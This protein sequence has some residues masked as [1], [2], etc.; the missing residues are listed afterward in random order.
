MAGQVHPYK[1][2]VCKQ[3]HLLGFPCKGRLWKSNTCCGLHKEPS[4]APVQRDYTSPRRVCVCV[5]VCVCMCETKAG[6][7]GCKS[8][9]LLVG[10]GQKSVSFAKALRIVWGFCVLLRS[11]AH[12]NE[13]THTYRYTLTKV[14][15]ENR[16]KWEHARAIAQV[17]DTFATNTHTHVCAGVYTHTH[18]HT[19]S[20]TFSRICD[21]LDWLK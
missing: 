21:L 7:G 17:T 16:K 11:N 13:H 12:K 20:T 18:T 2:L 5:C 1:N 3:R 14:C 19:H 4:N 9:F 15:S 8:R 10:V 6:C